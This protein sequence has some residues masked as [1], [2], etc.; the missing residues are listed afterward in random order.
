LVQAF[1]SAGTGFPPRWYRL[2]TLLVQAVHSTGTGFPFRCY[3]LSTPLEQA[4]R[5]A[6]TGFPAPA[7]GF[8]PLLH[9]FHPCYRLSAPATCFSPLLQAFRPCYMLF[10]PATGFPPLLHAFRPG[11]MLSTPATCFPPRLHAF[12]PCYSSIDRRS[13][14]TNTTYMYCTM[15]CRDQLSASRTKK[16]TIQSWLDECAYYCQDTSM[17]L[18]WMTVC[19]LRLLP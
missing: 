2:S 10:T 17:R 4:F 7:T 12:H 11:Y 8:P 14:L 16:T 13:H 19:W 5:S 9:A 18:S 1:H 3:R 15:L 6:A